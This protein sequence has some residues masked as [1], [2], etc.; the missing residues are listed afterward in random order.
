MLCQPGGRLDDRGADRARSNIAV[1]GGH[2]ALG[3][4][5]VA[6]RA[7]ALPPLHRCAVRSY[8]WPTAFQ[9]RPRRRV[10]LHPATLVYLLILHSTRNHA[11]RARTYVQNP[12]IIKP[13]SRSSNLLTQHNT[14]SSQKHHTSPWRPAGSSSPA[15]SC[16]HSSSCAST[17]RTAACRQVLR[18]SRCSATCCG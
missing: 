15:P 3:P 4:R 16:F 6:H 17:P 5:R 11:V 14:V 18:P 8:L 10:Y 12:T 7:D 9:A 13:E 1:A 2:A